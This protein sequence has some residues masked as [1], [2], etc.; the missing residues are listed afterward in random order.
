MITPSDMNWFTASV[1]WSIIGFITGMAVGYMLPRPSKIKVGKI[2]DQ[3]WF[4]Q[5]NVIVGVLFVFLAVS[6]IIQGVMVSGLSDR[7]DACRASNIE[8]LQQYVSKSALYD[9]LDTLALK[10]SS[11]QSKHLFKL[12][13]RGK[14][15]EAQRL[16][17]QVTDDYFK[18][19]LHIDVLRENLKATTQLEKCSSR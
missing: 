18:T 3:A 12:F 19:R 17:Q 16:Q 13:E 5:W 10:K 7:A 15:A 2:K 11:R 9:H 4:R 14:I 8:D 6:S 1:A